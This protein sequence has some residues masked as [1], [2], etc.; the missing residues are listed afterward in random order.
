MSEIQAQVIEQLCTEISARMNIMIDAEL[1]SLIAETVTIE[2]AAE[3]AVIVRD[4][5]EIVRRGHFQKPIAV[6]G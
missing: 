6:L 2:G 3:T 1:R 5:L 4:A